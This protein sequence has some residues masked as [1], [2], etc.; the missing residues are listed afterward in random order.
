MGWLVPVVA[1][2]AIGGILA[3]RFLVGKRE[4]GYL[5]LVEYWIYSPESKLPEQEAIMDRMIGKN[6]HNR[7]G[8]AAIGARE[9]MLFSDIR[10]HIGL[11]KREKNAHI[12][13]PDLFEA[14]AIPT[15]E[16]LERLPECQSMV[17][18]RYASEA[19]LRDTR[20]LQFMPH[21]ADAV[22]ELMGGRVI[23]DRISE[24]LYLSEE[25]H[26]LLAAN[27]NM[28]RPEAHVRVEWTETADSCYAETLG[29]KKVGLKEFVT[30]PQEADNEVLVKGLLMRLAF[31][32]VRDPELA[33]PWEFDEFG[34]VFVF[35][36]G[37]IDAEGRQIVHM[38]RR[39]VVG[40]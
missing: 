8:S 4:P 12:F 27:A 23:F 17:K 6:P 3:W 11:A 18:V 19:R 10:L 38:K 7:R 31:S 39:Q 16:M 28:E 9:G 5:A 26:G 24:K 36:L 33:E 29:L 40:G 32:L 20:H 15:K 14:K 25:F 35:T 2:L 34:D 13:R 21:L 1:V 30:D 22:S 37:E